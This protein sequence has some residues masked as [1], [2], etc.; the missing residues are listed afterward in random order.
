M[1]QNI[2]SSE[3]LDDQYSTIDTKPKHKEHVNLSSPLIQHLSV[4]GAWV[5]FI[6]FILPGHQES[7][8]VTRIFQ[9]AYNLPHP[10]VSPLL[11]YYW[12]I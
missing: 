1:Q 11:Y 4:K 6:Y 5:L 7:S 12:T 9:M 2:C 8:E 3:T 10:L